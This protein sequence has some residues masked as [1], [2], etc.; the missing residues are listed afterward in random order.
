MHDIFRPAPKTYRVAESALLRLIRDT[1]HLKP[2]YGVDLVC[3]RGIIG[4]RVVYMNRYEW[5]SNNEYFNHF[6]DNERAGV[7]ARYLTDPYNGLEDVLMLLVDLALMPND[8]ITL[9]IE[10]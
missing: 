7:I 9:I 10:E 8:N 5:E 6:R 3:G 1:F 2:D 4:E